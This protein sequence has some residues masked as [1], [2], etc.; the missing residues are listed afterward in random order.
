MATV[1]DIFKGT[2]RVD[3]SRFMPATGQEDNS[4][5]GT[6]GRVSWMIITAI[7]AAVA[8]LALAVVA[9]WRIM[10]C[11]RRV[12]DNELPD[13]GDAMG[14][15]R[16]GFSSFSHDL[17]ATDYENPNELEGMDMVSSDAGLIDDPDEL[18]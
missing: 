1:S 16:L 11:V 5:W 8:G 14:T 9:G 15:E 17:S 13:S 10:K 18:L 12:E 4:G 7:G 2:S 3:Q 6:V